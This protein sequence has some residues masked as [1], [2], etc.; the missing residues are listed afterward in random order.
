MEHNMLKDLSKYSMLIHYKEERN[1]KGELLFYTN[2]VYNIV[3]IDLVTNYILLANK[4]NPNNICLL[5]PKLGY[6]ISSIKHSK[7]EFILFCNNKKERFI[8]KK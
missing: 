2:Q 4:D 1:N 3:E 5:N 7:D 6:S 8:C